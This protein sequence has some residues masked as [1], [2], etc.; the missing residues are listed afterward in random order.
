[1]AKVPNSV[2]LILDTV[3]LGDLEGYFGKNIYKGQANLQKEG[4]KDFLS[5]IQASLRNEMAKQGYYYFGGKGD[6][7][8]QYFVK[9]HPLADMQVRKRLTSQKFLGLRGTEEQITRE[10]QQ[11]PGIKNLSKSVISSINS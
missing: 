6:A 11:R 3:S 1:M 5:N 2:E 7:H 9:L 10:F 4:Y 8:R